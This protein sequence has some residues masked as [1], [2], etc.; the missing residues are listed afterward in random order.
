MTTDAPDKAPEL[1]PEQL[2]QVL[3]QLRDSGMLSQLQADLKDDLEDDLQRNR[4]MGDSEG[5]EGAENGLG[6]GGFPWRYWKRN[7]GRVITGPEPRETMYAIFVAKGY[8]PLFEYGNLPSPGA[9]VPCCRHL[10]M[11]DNQYHILFAKGGAKELSVDQ[12]INAGW[13]EKPPTVHGKV[14]TFPQLAG[15]EIETVE[16][17]ECD[18]PLYGIRGTPRIIQHMR[19]HGRAQHGWNRRETNEMLVEAGYLSELPSSTRR[20]L[21]PATQAAI[22]NQL[23]DEEEMTPELLRAARALLAQQKQQARQ[24]EPETQAPEQTEPTQTAPTPPAGIKVTK[25]ATGK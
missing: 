9:P 20:S 2:Q 10:S 16:C 22:A 14:V 18:K 3:K 8:Q 21:S 11:K 23:E 4:F 24:P 25:G 19:Q 7:D 15:I 12:I 6:S 13:H 5:L 1:T 17:P